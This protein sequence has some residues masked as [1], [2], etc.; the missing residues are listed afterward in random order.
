[1]G[2]NV[3]KRHE[4]VLHQTAR[5]QSRRRF[6]KRAGIGVIGAGL[7]GYGS[8]L[9]SISYISKKRQRFI[10]ELLQDSEIPFCSGV[11]YDHTGSKIIRFYTEATRDSDEKDTFIGGEA[12][13]FA[14][15]DYDVKTP[16]V[17][18]TAGQ[19]ESVPIF[20]GRQLF[21]SPLF[22]Y[23]TSEDIRHILIAHEGHHCLQHAKGMKFISP[24]EILQGLDSEQLHPSLLYYAMEYDAYIHDFPRALRGEFKVSRHHLED[25]KRRFVETRNR[26]ESARKIARP[27]ELRIIHSLQEA[28]STIP[29]LNNLSVSQ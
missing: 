22:S 10:D 13:E 24:K 7:L 5:Q 23:Y 26:F 11:V 19:G 18:Q 15:G 25:W 20:I 9:L 1:M 2:V 6:L 27:L 29:E 17:L 4:Q 16:D 28:A 14:G 12:E 3:R 21:D 8:H